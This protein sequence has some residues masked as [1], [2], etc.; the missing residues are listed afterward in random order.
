[1]TN[2]S[3]PKPA[4][5]EAPPATRSLILEQEIAA[6][7]DEVWDA[8]TTP[9]GIRRW[10]ALDARVTP[11]ASGSVWLSWGP[12]CEGEAPIHIWEPAER[13]GW[14]EG[15]G[16][17]DDGR[18][19]RVAIDFYIESREGSTVLRL[20]QSGFS[21]SSDWDE[22]YDALKDGWTYFL[23]NLAFYFL[24]HRGQERRLVW[25]RVP[26]DLA[27]EDI[28]E[29]LGAGS[30]IGPAGNGD[31]AGVRIVIDERRPAEVVSSRKGY[32]FAA[33]LPDLNRS[34]LFVELE[35][36]HVGLWLSTYGLDAKQAEDLQE[37]LDGRVEVV[38]GVGKHTGSSTESQSG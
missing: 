18:P 22:M 8:L 13:F 5:A 10:L 20:V 32:H 9:A 34:L 38:F 33:T 35:G 3:D 17:D 14:T 25:R 28:W 36:Q 7:P 15:Y 19:I 16:D 30:L 2:K 11:G 21:A 6:P 27:R 12:G 26:T 37:A 4:G 24:E 23:F 1:M 31:D 29:R